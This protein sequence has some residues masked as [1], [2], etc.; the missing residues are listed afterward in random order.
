MLSEDKNIS[1]YIGFSALTPLPCIRSFFPSGKQPSFQAMVGC[2][3]HPR[4]PGAAGHSCMT[5]LPMILLSKDH[6]GQLT[7][8]L[9][10]LFP[11]AVIA[12][13]SSHKEE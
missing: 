9:L 8:H 6:F 13:L 10:V 3:V 7:C 12:L 1:V 11:D 4:L 2:H 5:F